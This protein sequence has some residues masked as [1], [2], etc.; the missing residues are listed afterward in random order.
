MFPGG[1]MNRSDRREV[2]AFAKRALGRK[3]LDIEYPGGKTRD[4]VR[5]ILPA[6]RSVIATRRPSDR[7]A[8]HEVRVLKALREGGAP[9]PKVYAFNG[10]ILL[11]QDLGTERL[12]QSLHDPEY[13]KR[14]PELLDA[15]LAAMAA[16]HAAAAKTDLADDLPVI[17]GEPGW[18][19]GLA[20][21]PDE[22]GEMSGI[23]PPA[24]DR[25]AVA[26]VIKVRKPA[27]VKWDSRPGNALIADSGRAYWFDWEH[28]GLRNAVD[29]FVWLMADEFV[30]H[31]PDME[32]RLFDAYLMAFADGQSRDETE[33]Y[34][35]I[36]GCF[37]T[38]VRLELILDNKGSG[39]WWSLRKCLD[40]DKVGI[41]RRC[42]RRI[43]RRA[44]AWA[45][46]DPITRPLIPW[47][48][49]LEA[50]IERI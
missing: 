40:G 6:G 7:R 36:L 12:S 15:S 8:E 17:G 19:Q 50:Y 47:Y 14:I 22:V 23:Q 33:R 44:A 16:V 10:T 29:D 21:V 25:D 30:T 31:V 5:L 11:Q 45:D 32:A 41:T 20:S 42:C 24:Y 46:F 39:D 37:H 27:F 28:C 13:A 48:Q 35:R 34:V 49:D 3:V 43:L 26:E 38:C 1:I 4:S 2:S 18:C 9:V